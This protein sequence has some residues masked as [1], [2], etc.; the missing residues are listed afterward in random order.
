MKIT[1]KKI[2]IGMGLLG[3]GALVAGGVTYVI[4]KHNKS[5]RVNKLFEHYNLFV[6]TYSEELAPL[7]VG[8][9]NKLDWDKLLENGL[10]IVS[11]LRFVTDSKDTIDEFVDIITEF[12]KLNPTVMEL[13]TYCV[14]I[15]TLLLEPLK[16]K[17]FSS[18]QNSES[19][20]SEETGKVED[21]EAESKAK[22]P[23]T[24][25]SVEPVVETAPEP[26]N[27][28]RDEQDDEGDE[29]ISTSVSTNTDVTEGIDQK[30]QSTPKT[31][32]PRR[33]MVKIKKHDS[34]DTTIPN[35]DNIDN[36]IEDE[37]SDDA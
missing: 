21:I 2:G 15:D 27:S 13:E 31:K 26:E 37:S 9:V 11:G 34:V 25:Q 33:R 3:A 7:E 32:T 18:L 16:E 10:T 5:C 23:D 36:I 22:E 17:I 29:D 20:N 4:K 6:E 28:N 19:T 14:S 24:N 35:D 30:Q 12:Y 1:G 8:T